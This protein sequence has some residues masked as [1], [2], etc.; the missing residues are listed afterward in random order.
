VHPVDG[1]C[2]VTRVRSTLLPMTITPI[3]SE[4]LTRPEPPVWTRRHMLAALGVG[5]ATIVVAGT[6]AM[7]YRVYDTAALSPARGDAYDPWKHWHDTPGL[8]GAVASAVLAASPHNTQP[9]IFGVRDRAVDVF[10]DRARGTGTVDPFAREQHMGI[11]CAIENLALAC[12][13]RGLVPAVTLLPD[14]PTGPRL[15]EIAVTAGQPAPSPLYDAIGDRHTN[16]GPYDADRPGRRRRTARTG[17]ALG[18]GPGTPHRPR[19][20]SGRRRGG[21][22]RRRAAVPGQLRLVPRQQRRRPAPP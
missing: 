12:A 17:R 8:V 16:R 18:R 20:A 21:T 9:W 3:E 13:A 10:V 6:G 2:A 7:S 14:G 1:W 11:G 4:V 19:P 5:G 15:A 22:V